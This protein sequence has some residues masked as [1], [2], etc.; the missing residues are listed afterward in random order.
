MLKRSPAFVV[1]LGTTIT[2]RCRYSKYRK[3]LPVVCTPER[4]KMEDR[5]GRRKSRG[6]LSRARRGGGRHH[7]PQGGT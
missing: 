6:R 4:K 3:S 7:P 2:Q 1:L 5:S